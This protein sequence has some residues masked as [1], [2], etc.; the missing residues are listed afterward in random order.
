MP[1]PKSWLAFLTMDLTPTQQKAAWRVVW[2]IVLAVALAGGYGAFSKA[3]FGGFAYAGD[4]DKVRDEVASIRIEL[5]EQRILDARMRQCQR[6]P[7]EPGSFYQRELQ[8]QLRRYREIAR[9]EY[10][11]PSCAEL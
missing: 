1:D 3:G 10:R 11:L 9:A 2:R 4:V 6:P 8:E 5:I 7:S